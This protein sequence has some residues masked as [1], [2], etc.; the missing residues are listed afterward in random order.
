MQPYPCYLLDEAISHEEDTDSA[1]Q[2]RIEGNK[3]YKERL[4]ITDAH[5]G[6]KIDVKDTEGIWC[7][8]TIKTVMKVEN[9]K[10]V[11]VHFDRWDEFFDELI[12]LD[13]PRLAPEGFFTTRDIFR[14]K[15]LLSD[16]NKQGEII[17]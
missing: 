12:P 17:K 9:N 13:S 7:I 14:Y 11:L 3:Q 2:V 1:Y 15:L 6:M 5:E 8:G 4:R 10:L 16:G